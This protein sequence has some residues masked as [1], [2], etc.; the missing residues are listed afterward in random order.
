MGT[1]KQ[2][3]DIASGGGGFFSAA[4][5]LAAGYSYRQLSY[6]VS[7][8]AVERA[9]RGVYRLTQYPAH[10]HADLI[11][12]TLWAGDDSAVSHDTALA[13]YGLGVAMPPVIHVTVPR[14]FRGSRRG[15]H[16]H[17]APLA[18]GDRRLWDDVPVTSVERTLIDVSASADPSLVADAVRDALTRG[19][20]TQ[21]RLIRAVPEGRDAE[22]LRRALAVSPSGSA[23]S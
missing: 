14:Q 10:P 16:V 19:L 1:R 11:A 17:I 5:A 18:V 4:A 8:G 6:Y 22:P 20:T 7:T 12:A 9:G 21:R 3:Y 15:V 2:L 13:V 23:H